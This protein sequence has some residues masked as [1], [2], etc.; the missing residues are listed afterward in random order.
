MLDL[1]G[2]LSMPNVLRLKAAIDGQ[3]VGFIAC[4]IR[5]SENVAWIATI[6]VMPEQRRQGIGE[7]LLREAESRL[8]VSWLRLSVRA[9]NQDAIRLY[10]RL[11]YV[12]KTIWP[13]YYADREDA[14][15]MEKWVIPAN[16]L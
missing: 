10:Q 2:V 6:G 16:G 1:V 14:V 5:R 8:D 4:D 15:V 7:L 3:M 13:A 11:G 12:Q 9:S